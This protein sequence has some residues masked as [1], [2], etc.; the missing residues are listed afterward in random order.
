M[1]LN[2]IFLTFAI[3]TTALG[4]FF[5]KKYSLSHSYKFFYLTIILFIVTPVFSY[6]ALKKIPIDIVYMFTSLTIL[7]VLFLSKIFLNEKIASKTYVG[8]IFIIL[9][10]ILYGI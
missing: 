5:Y 8:V 6:M 10:V 9:G 3:F 2:Y 4:Q 1:S 7:I